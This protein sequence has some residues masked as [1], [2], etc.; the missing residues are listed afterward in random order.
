MADVGILNDPLS[1]AFVVF[2]IGSPGLVAGALAGAILW[3]GR[4]VLGALTGAL[5]GFMLWF[6]GWT[7]ING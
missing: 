4:R 6:A 1:I 3:R 5:V 2:I 7:W